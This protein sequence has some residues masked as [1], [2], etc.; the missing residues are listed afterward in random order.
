[1]NLALNDSTKFATGV[2]NLVYRPA[3]A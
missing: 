2:V 3:D 1:V